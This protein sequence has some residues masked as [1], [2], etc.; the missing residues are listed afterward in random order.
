MNYMQIEK[1]CGREI[2]DS[3]GNPTVEAEVTLMDGSVGRGTAPSERAFQ[4]RLIISIPLLTTLLVIWTHRIFML[5][6]RR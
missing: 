2:L 3:R 4:R 6:I 1:V 5:L